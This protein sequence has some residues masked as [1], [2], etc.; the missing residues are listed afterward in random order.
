[1]L[2]PKVRCEAEALVVVR[3]AGAPRIGQVVLHDQLVLEGELVVVHD[4]VLGV[5]VSL[6]MRFHGAEADVGAEVHRDVL[7]I[8][9]GENLLNV[10]LLD[11]DPA[12]RVIRV[13]DL[14]SE[15]VHV[16]DLVA[17][18]V[19]VPALGVHQV[20]GRGRRRSSRA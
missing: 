8:E 13:V 6:L 14:D 9:D 10:R 4:E 1:M 3:N 19:V 15:E 12:V 20:E 7:V 2:V 11:V 18:V 5:D 17:E 16:G